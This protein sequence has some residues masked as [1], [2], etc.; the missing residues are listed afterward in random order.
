M[1]SWVWEHFKKEDGKAICQHKD[2]NN[3]ICGAKLALGSN[4]SSLSYHLTSKHGL[5]KGAPSKKQRL[6]PQQQTCM[7]NSR[8][9]ALPTFWGRG[10]VTSKACVLSQSEEF[11]LTWALNGLAHDLVEEKHFRHLFTM[12]IPPGTLLP[13]F[14]QTPGLGP[15]VG[16]LMSHFWIVRF[17]PPC[18][19]PL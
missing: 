17:Q 5:A 14:L 13:P 2:A 8:R 7:P 6:L 4:T 11:C 19:S 18:S 1:S 9:L 3:V 15:F 16:W 12:V 10:L